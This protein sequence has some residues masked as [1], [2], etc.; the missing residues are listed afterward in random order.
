MRKSLFVVAVLAVIGCTTAWAIQPV[1]LVNPS[2]EQPGTTKQTGFTAVTGWNMTAPVKNSGVEQGYG[3]TNGTWTAYL[4]NVDP[5]LWQLTGY[6]VVGGQTFVLSVDAQITWIATTMRMGLF[7]DVNGVHTVIASQDVALTSS[8]VKY[9]LRATID[10][11]SAGVGRKLGIMFANATPGTTETWM[12]LDNVQ[13]QVIVPTGIKVT[14]VTDSPDVDKNGVM[15]DQGWIDW[16]TDEGHTV[17]ARRG[18]YL[19]PLD[20]NRIIELNAA[21]VIISSRGLSTTNYYDSNGTEATKWNSL[22]TPMIGMNPY[23]LR[24]DRWKWIKSTSA[25]GT[26]GSP[27]MQV[28]NSTNAIFAGVTIAPGDPNDPNTQ[29]TVAVVDATIGS[30]NTSFMNS[31]DAGN[32]TVLGKTAGSAGVPW[33]IEWKSGLEYYAG[34]GQFAGDHR[35]AFYAGTQDASTVQGAFNLTAQGQIMFRNAINYVIAQT[36]P[37]R[38]PQPAVGATGVALDATLS[39]R[40]GKLAVNHTLYLSSNMADVVSGKAIINVV[41]A[42]SYNLKSLGLILGTT[43]YWKIVETNGAQ[44]WTSE[45][46]SFKTTDYLVVDDFESYDNTSILKTWVDGFLKG[47][48]IACGVVPAVGTGIVHGGKQ[49]MVLNFDNSKPPFVTDTQRV[50]SI[51][52]WM[53]TNSGITTLVLWFYGDPNNAAQPLYA[54]V[55]GYTINYGGDPLNVTKATWTQWNISVANLPVPTNGT[56]TLNIGLGAT[57]QKPIITGTLGGDKGVLYI[58]DIRLYRVAP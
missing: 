43:Y 14:Y 9:T 21:D 20:P 22:K 45:I 23:L 42:N 28:L 13:L 33:I 24:S 10:A 48:G 47:T 51:Q 25:V 16:L 41:T 26:M 34:A 50:T 40:P 31:V 30:G 5:N 11:K 6:T 2:F 37:A 36:M 54:E 35:L 12:G 52:N 1:T 15:D 49:A 44:T 53:T 18:Y 19:K 39:W 58:D 8:M 27:L 46:W 4:D 7:Y 56:I 55:N 29:N 3:A 38:E 32:G 57:V 17:D